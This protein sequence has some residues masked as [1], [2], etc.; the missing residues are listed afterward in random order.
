MSSVLSAVYR[1][2]CGCCLP[3]AQAA[4]DDDDDRPTTLSSTVLQ[5]VMI[6][7]SSLS[8]RRR[9]SRG[10]GG[11]CSRR[12]TSYGAPPYEELDLGHEFAHFLSQ[13]NQ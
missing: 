8:H 12:I 2:C 10:N 13:E 4:A 3:A 1:L 7:S 9:L 6:L 5:Q 11:E